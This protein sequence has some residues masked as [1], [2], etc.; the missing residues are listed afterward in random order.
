[1]FFSQRRPEELKEFHWMIDAK[2]DAGAPTDWEQWWVKFILPVLQSRT[3]SR[4]IQSLPVG[5]YSF[6]KRFEIPLTPFLRQH[7]RSKDNGAPAMNFA[8]ILGEHWMFSK[9]PEPGI[10]LVDIITNATRRALIGHL[11]RSG[12]RD[13]PTLMIHRNP[14]PYIKLVSLLD[15]P[16]APRGYDYSAVL[17]EFGQRGRN[18][19]TRKTVSRNW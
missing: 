5:D 6:M 7:R 11:G 12:Y 16:L 10:E 2:G 14:P 1:M 18:M 8:M 13:I 17:Q 3:L 19:S 9:D 15:A 4:P